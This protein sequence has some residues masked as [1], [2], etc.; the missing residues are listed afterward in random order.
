MDDTVAAIVTPLGA[1]GL[2]VLRLSGPAALA[3]AGRVFRSALPLETAPSHTVHHGVLHDGGAAVD[4][5]VA[6]LFRAPR[7]YTGEDVVEF[8]CHGSPA[9]LRRALDLLLKNGA[10]AAG[11]GEFT[12]R[13]Y[14]NG[15]MDLTQAEAVAA[16]INARSDDARRWALEQLQ[17][18]LSLHVKSLRQEV[19]A[20]LAHVEAG[21]D[22][23]DDEVPDLARPELLRRLDALAAKA[24]TLL[25]TAPRGR[26]FRDGLRAALAGRPNA[27]KSSLFNA[28]LGADRA[29]VTPTPGTTR[30]TLEET[31][32]V[33]GL[34]LV[35]TDTAGLR[36]G[37]E[38]VEAEGILRAQRVLEEADA[39]LWV[40]DAAAPDGAE[41]PPAASPGAPVILVLNKCD[42]LPAGI[43]RMALVAGKNA[44]AHRAAVFV[45]AKTGEGLAEL[46][47]TLASLGP[48]SPE[49]AAG[50]TLMNDRHA[51]RVRDA[52][53]ALD[54]AVAAARAGDPEECVALELRRSLDAF[55]QVTGMGVPEEVL[56][57]V[58][59]RFCIG[60]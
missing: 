33:D 1:G 4:D 25:A 28:L 3:V 34:P 47:K 23:V 37:A 26:L 55:D 6:A 13:A 8:S 32:L 30:D 29:I 49:A 51:D 41:T 17:G 44:R 42:L 19:I 7:S 21:L 46:K 56:D 14:L 18:K 35:L 40:V 31:I 5:A 57:A 53:A 38:A 12:K 9:L 36:D 24:G 16:L 2:G 39:V 27:G 48:A 43:D 11:P 10:R 60:K 20:L 22:F 52:A 45:S 58:F 15:K 50:P 54:A 59:A